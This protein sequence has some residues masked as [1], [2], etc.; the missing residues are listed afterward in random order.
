MITFKSRLLLSGIGGIALVVGA[1]AMAQAQNTTGTGPFTQ[2]QVDAGRAAYAGNC[3]DC[4]GANLGGGPNGPGLYGPGFMA[5]WGGQT[6]ADYYKFMSATMP[7]G[8]EGRLPADTYASIASF[9]YAANGARPGTQTYMSF[10][11]FPIT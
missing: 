1:Y 11:R 8:N 10:F 3:A 7:Y 6:T 2:A 5:R 9:I 4:H